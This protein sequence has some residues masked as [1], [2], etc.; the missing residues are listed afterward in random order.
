MRNGIGTFFYERNNDWYTGEF[1]DDNRDGFGAY[2]FS[3]GAV[4]Y[5]NWFD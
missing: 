1:F 3:N 2:W 4:Y 5:G